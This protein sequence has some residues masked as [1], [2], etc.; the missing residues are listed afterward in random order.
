MKSIKKKSLLYKSSVEYSDFSINHIVG[1]AHGCRF[2][3]YAYLM[4]KRFGWVKDYNDWIKPKIVSNALE[5]LDKEIPKYKD[6]IKFV[7]LCFMTDPFMYKYPEVS[8]LT[9]K[10]IERL[11][12][13]KIRSMVLTKG[14]YPKVLIK[15]DRYGNIN[16]YGITLIS[17]NNKFKKVFEPFSAPYQKRINALRYLHDHGLNT[18]VS[19]EPYPTPNLVDQDL[20]GLLKKVAFVD[21]II[22]GKLNYNATSTKFP[23]NK[24]FYEKCAKTVATFCRENG[25][26]FHIKFGTQEKYNDQTVKIFH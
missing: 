2:P 15:K 26:D 3:C 21:K 5:L 25:I 4:A 6:E 8:N 16:D 17:M 10:I 7:H 14:I 18:W 23:N 19:M 1:C 12:K 20:L 9:L 24:D 11:W 13:D 22:F